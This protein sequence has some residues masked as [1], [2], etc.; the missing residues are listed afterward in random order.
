MV[1][2]WRNAGDWSTVL[3]KNHGCLITGPDIRQA[4]L[5]GGGVRSR[6]KP[7]TNILRCEGLQAGA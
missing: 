7:Q 1:C 3:V 4:T 2:R 6:R 5:H